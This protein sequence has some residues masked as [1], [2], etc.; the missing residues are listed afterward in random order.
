MIESIKSKW[1]VIILGFS[2]IGLLSFLLSPPKVETK[3]EKV[4]IETVNE[5][6]TTRIE[7]IKAKDGTEKVVI[8]KTK[9]VSTNKTKKIA[10]TK[11]DVRESGKHNISVIYGLDIEG[12]KEVF[13][14]HYTQEIGFGVNVGVFGL[15]N[16]TLGVSVGFRY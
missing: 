16:K 4:S 9:D 11:I 14:L 15:T 10:E 2:A 6:E 12:K 7:K 13:G 1:P 3:T 8:T 5:R